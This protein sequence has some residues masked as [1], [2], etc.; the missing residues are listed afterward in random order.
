MVLSEGLQ[1]IMVKLPKNLLSEVD[2]FMKYENSDLSEFIYQ[3]TKNYLR[4]KKDEHVH[5]F[6]ESMRVGY[7]EM[8]R[9]NLTIASESFQAEEEA[10]VTMKRAVIGV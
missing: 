6:R 3:A 2:G 1:E 9:I 7:Q 8:A 5:Q 4:A 10:E